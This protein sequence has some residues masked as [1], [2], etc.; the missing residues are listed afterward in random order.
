MNKYCK[1]CDDLNDKIKTMYSQ[2]AFGSICP[3]NW[4]EISEYLKSETG[5]RIDTLILTNGS[6]DY[7]DLYETDSHLWEDFCSMN[8]PDC[9]KMIFDEICGA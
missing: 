2:D 4:D 6:A 7:D 3:K 1:L 5:R 8:L 9:P